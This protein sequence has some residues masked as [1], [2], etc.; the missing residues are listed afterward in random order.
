M[1]AFLCETDNEWFL[2]FCSVFTLLALPPRL[3]ANKD[4]WTS[5]K[6]LPRSGM[7]FKPAAILLKTTPPRVHEARQFVNFSSETA[8]RQLCVVA[9]PP[10]QLQEAFG[11]PVSEYS[12]C[13]FYWAPRKRELRAVRWF[14][15]SL[16]L[17]LKI[18]WTQKG[19]NSG[20]SRYP[21]PIPP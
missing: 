15:S 7:C 20:R 12:V 6:E 16:H 18:F 13:L 19:V 14:G 17:I 10:Q 5:H 4:A 2:F 21:S 8:S 1:K 11:H 9:R 3:Q